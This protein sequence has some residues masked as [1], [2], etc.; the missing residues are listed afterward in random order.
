VVT[1]LSGDEGYDRCVLN[2]FRSLRFPAREG[3]GEIRLDYR[4]GIDPIR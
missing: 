2:L 3:D 4:L 1:R